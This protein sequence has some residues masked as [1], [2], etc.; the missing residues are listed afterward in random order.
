[1]SVGSDVEGV[2]SASANSPRWAAVSARAVTRR[3]VGPARCLEERG[4]PEPRHFLEAEPNNEAAD[5]GGLGGNELIEFV[6][7]DSIW[8]NFASIIAILLSVLI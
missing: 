7:L 1:L 8:R 4:P 6:V 2:A 3:T 5:G